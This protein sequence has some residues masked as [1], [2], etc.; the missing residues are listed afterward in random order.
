MVD[1]VVVLRITTPMQPKPSSRRFLLIVIC[2]FALSHLVS[3]AT[4]LGPLVAA[5]KPVDWWFVFKFNADTFPGDD[6]KEPAPTIFGGTPTNYHGGFSLSYAYA[7]SA[8]PTLRMGTN[9][10]GLSLDD[11]LGATFDQIYH[12]TCNYVLWNDQ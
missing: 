5:G 2:I 3:A 4:P 6:S 7:S 9:Y 10:I 1:T 8:D 12:G 11:P